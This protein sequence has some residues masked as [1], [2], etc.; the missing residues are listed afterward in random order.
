MRRLAFLVLAS[1]SIC[2]PFG[3]G[4]PIDGTTSQSARLTDDTWTTKR[5]FRGGE[6]ACVLAIGS[7]RDPGKLQV[8]V[9]DEKGNVVAEERAGDSLSGNIVA[10]MWYPPR[11]GEYRI[12]VRS[13]GASDCYVAIK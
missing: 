2:T 11:D 5:L 7:Q 1:L 4:S 3:V 9:H 13:P 12:S 8:T 6:R 10:V